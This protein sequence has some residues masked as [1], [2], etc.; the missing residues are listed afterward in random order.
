MHGVRKPE[1]KKPFRRLRCR[2]GRITLKW[3]LN[4]LY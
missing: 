3:I 1:E 2:N 4:E